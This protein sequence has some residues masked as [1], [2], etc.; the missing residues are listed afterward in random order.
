MIIGETAKDTDWKKR[1]FFILTICCR[2]VNLTRQSN[3][4]ADGKPDRL[5]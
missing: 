5:E 2:M 4:E 1:G 3:P